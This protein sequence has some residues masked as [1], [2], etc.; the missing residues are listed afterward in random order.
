[1]SYDIRKTKEFGMAKS[2]WGREYYAR[3]AMNWLVPVLFVPYFEWDRAGRL[4]LIGTPTRMVRRSVMEINI[5]PMG[6][7]LPTV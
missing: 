5:S 1:M 2:Q 6:K 3:D 7:L 4:S